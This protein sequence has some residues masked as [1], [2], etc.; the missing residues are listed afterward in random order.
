MSKE[1]IL[2]QYF[3]YKVFR[4]GQEALIDHI[5]R[6]DDALGIMPTGAGKSL[7]FQVPAMLFD[8]ITIVIS[9][10]IS[11]MRDQVQALITN[12]IPAAFVNS[13]LNANQTRAA[14]ENARNGKYKIIYVAPERLDVE[15][16][17]SF[18]ATANISMVTVDEAHCVSQWGQ[19]FRPSYLKINDF[20]DKLPKRPVISAFTATAT[21]EVKDDI[22]KILKLNQPFV[23]ATGF[24]RENLYFEVQKPNDKYRSVINYLTNNPDKSGIIYCATRKTVEQVC[25]DL[26]DDNYNATRY[27]AGLTE[28]ERTKNQDDFLYDRKTIMVATNA[29]GM[30]IDKSN[31][32]FVIHY[33]M[34]KNIESYYQEAGRAG[35][36]G[37]NADCILLYGGQD[38]VT[39][40]F[41]IDHT[42]EKNDLD[43]ETLELV[44]AKERERLK[45]MTYYCHTT[46]CLRNYILRYF[47]DKSSNY[48]GN[49][50][51]CKQ[52]FETTDILDYSKKIISC[53]YRMKE[54]YGIQMVIDTLRGSRNEKILKLQLD[55]LS[56]Y[57]IMKEV[58]Q[59][60]IRDIINYLVLNEYIVLTNSEF[61]VAKLG[62]NYK[63]LLNSDQPVLMKIQKASEKI[64][65]ETKPG[66]T[67]L[68]KYVGEINQ[69]LLMKFKELRLKIAAENK[70]PAF[71]IF[72][73]ATLIDMCK[74]KPKNKAEMLEVS[75]VGDV[76]FERY[77][78]LFLNIISELDIEN[79]EINLP[80]TKELSF[81]EICKYVR[82]EFQPTEEE[83]TVS[84]LTDMLNALLLQKSECKLT[85][86]KMSL[87]YERKG[88]LRVETIDEKNNRIA[89]E[90]GNKLGVS[91]REITYSNGKTFKQNFYN[92]N[93]QQFA[94][95]HID[96]L[97]RY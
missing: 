48:C 91:T 17:V 16:F 70:V 87:F 56:T 29:F 58:H 40:Q 93:A 6:H 86:V 21:S 61:P 8:G 74:K 33:N 60:H 5:L 37:T 31:V 23:V 1:Q 66:K 49:C 41:F 46:D 42:N 9:P 59:S 55:K 53:I 54:R 14:I 15:E 97:I 57:G 85:T 94:V 2:K 78:E 88:F 7:C 82:E 18:S 79:N 38:V 26:T 67:K 10:L 89:T 19:D 47:G 77:G 84:I 76:K 4:E 83:V 96:E 80:A 3:G 27:H 39:N 12:G 36:D 95:E 52:N 24:D 69:E 64:Q 43:P 45:Q 92:K 50:G 44:K 51:N 90:Q 32:N 13:S 11:L 22:I 71:V 73:D 62:V 28:E 75:G 20:I 35:R 65:K 63:E 72:S 30:G 25:S 34:P 81:E 68:N